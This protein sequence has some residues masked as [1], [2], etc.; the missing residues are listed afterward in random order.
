MAPVE[1]TEGLRVRPRSPQELLVGM[2][3]RQLHYPE[4]EQPTE[5][6]TALCGLRPA[7]SIWNRW[8]PAPRRSSRPATDRDCC[9]PLE[10]AL[11]LLPQSGS[12]LPLPAQALRVRVYIGRNAVPSDETRERSITGLRRG[13]VLGRLSTDTFERRVECAVSSQDTAEVRALVDGLP[14]GPISRAGS[15]LLDAI[16][17]LWAQPES[18]PSLFALSA[19]TRVRVGRSPDCDVVLDDLSVSRIHAELEVVDGRWNLRDTG[20]T[21]GTWLNGRRLRGQVEL[22]RGDVLTFGEVT[23][24]F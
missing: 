19:K 6:V 1:D 4:F 21:N 20:S 9:F 22:R 23:A 16:R 8:P 5:S 3:V 15:G 11:P 17:R 12:R 13:Y 10:A 2:T 7:A 24:R 18:P 14:G